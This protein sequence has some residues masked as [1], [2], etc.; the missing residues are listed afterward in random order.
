MAVDGRSI[1][2]RP[3]FVDDLTLPE[4]VGVLA[5]EVMHIACMHHTRRGGRD[6]ADWNRAGDYAIN[7]LLQGSGVTLPKGALIDPVLSNMSAEEIYKIIHAERPPEQS[8]GGGGGQGEG[9]KSDPGG[10]G[11]VWDAPGEDGQSLASEAE[12][13][14]AESE[15]KI[16]TVQAAQAAKR[17]GKMPAGLARVIDEAK[18]SRVDWREVL[19]AFVEEAAKTEYSWSRPNRRH[20][21]DG[22]YLPSLQGRRMGAIV[23]GVDTSGSID[24]DVLAAFRGEVR[25][26]VEELEPAAVHVVYCDSAVA[27]VDTFEAGDAVT[28]KARGGGGTAFQPVF[29]RVDQE[30]WSP[31]VLVYLTDTDGPDPVDPGYPVIW[32]GYKTRWSE[33]RA[34]PFGELI[35]VT[36]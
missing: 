30:G 15:A 10:C 25:A 36:A 5:H 28:F 3:S 7:G 27:G 32:A 11:E 16:A 21:A 20:I 13:A 12:L 24:R 23:V 18:A 9:E 6:A 8:G 29:D 14:Q 2:Y 22:L 31:A 1:Y 33:P 17:A 4:A 35:V 34:M 19:R 26:I